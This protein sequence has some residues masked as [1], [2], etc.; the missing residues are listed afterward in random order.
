[1]KTIARVLR[2][3]GLRGLADKLDPP[4]APQE[5]GPRPQPPV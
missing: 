1:M 3:L 4:A 2:W 5:G